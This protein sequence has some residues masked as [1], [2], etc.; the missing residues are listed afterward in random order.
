MKRFKPGN[1]VR[2]TRDH[3]AGM[4]PGNT[5]IVSD[6]N[7]DYM[8]LRNWPGIHNPESFELVADDEASVKDKLEMFPDERITTLG[9][10]LQAVDY[11]SQN[12][13]CCGIKEYHGIQGFA[14]LERDWTGQSIRYHDATPLD[15]L[16]GMCSYWRS[17]GIIGA[18][19]ECVRAR[20]FII[21]SVARDPECPA[22][23]C[24]RGIEV[25]DLILKHDLGSVWTSEWELNGNSGNLVQMYVWTVNRKTTAKAF[26]DAQHP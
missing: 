24:T 1:V 9:N 8:T 11:K 21:F 17:V 18:N 22:D 23:E 13:H 3:N 5:G 19:G 4:G 6:I 14:R 7:G 10:V 20:P 2:R 25:R 16:K 15:V 26:V 12:L